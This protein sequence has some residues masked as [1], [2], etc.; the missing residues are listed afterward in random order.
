MRILV[1]SDS[2]GDSYAVKQALM[3]QPAAKIVFF[4]GDGERD[5]EFIDSVQG[6]YVHKVRGNC[7]FA[8]ALPESVI[9]EVEGVRIYAT[10]G[11]VQRVKYGTSLLRQYAADNNAAIALYGHTHVADTTYSDGIWLVNPGSIRSGEY[12]VIDITPSGIMPILM[13][14]KY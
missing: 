6:V 4:L 13:K 5:L 3:E 1:I 7:D 2:H 10:H 11:Y 8:S 14:L 9:D 12:A